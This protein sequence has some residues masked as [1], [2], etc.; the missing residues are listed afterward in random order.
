MQLQKFLKNTQGAQ[1][2][3]FAF[4]APVLLTMLLGMVEIS[5]FIY[6]QQKT[7]K[8]AYSLADMVS[9]NAAPSIAQ[10]NQIFELAQD[11]VRPFDAGP[12][13]NM[14]I[15]AVNNTGAG[16]VVTWQR[17]PT[18][19]DATPR[20][21]AEGG[22]ANFG[23]LGAPATFAVG[24][25]EGVYAIEVLYKY[26]TMFLPNDLLEVFVGDTQN[27]YHYQIVKPRSGTTI[28]RPS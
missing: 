3:E 13:L 24:N 27:V 9:Q 4:I 25:G 28:P 14:T 26:Q 1:A 6:I 18:G 21:G 15:S 20:I 11:N 12:R 23:G 2:V 7:S 22:N 19:S 5:R 17:R 8:A 16:N 10:I